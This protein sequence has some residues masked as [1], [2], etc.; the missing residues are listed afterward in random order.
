MSAGRLTHF[1][2]DGHS[3][4][5]ELDDDLMVELD[6][7]VQQNQLTRM[8]FVKS[9]KA[10]ADLMERHPVLVERLHRDK[11]AKIDRAYLASRLREKENRPSMMSRASG[12]LLK[13]FDVTQKSPKLAGKDRRQSD[14]KS[15]MLRAASSG[16]DL[17]FEMD[18]DD[19]RSRQP[20]TP[21][22][23]S[24]V[25][26][27]LAALELPE[28]TE[29]GLEH[30]AASAGSSLAISGPADP[31]SSLHARKSNQKLPW[32]KSAMTNSKLDMKEIMAQASSNRT[33]TISTALKQPE[34]S[35]STSTKLSQKERKKLQQQQQ[36]QQAQPS[37]SQP[38][39]VPIP[40]AKGKPAPWQRASSGPRVSLK[41]VI[42]IEASSHS[43]KK[44][45]MPNSPSMTLRQTVSGR[46][47]AR[48]I[49]SEPAHPSASAHRTVSPTI[50]KAQPSTPSPGRP[51]SSS[52]HARS[53]PSKPTLS[54][55]HSLTTYTAT[56]QSIQ[57]NTP[58]SAEPSLQLS[59]QDILAQQ[60]MQKDVL[61]DAVA[62]R[63]LQ[64]IQEEQAFQEWWDEESR[65]VQEREGEK[66]GKEM[67]KRG[68]RLRRG[69]SRGR[70]R[71]RG[72]G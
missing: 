53:T 19:K 58:S 59:M 18:E 40:Q 22:T 8:S 26:Q 36:L 71:G 43:T 72:G 6:Q 4:L 38:D 9:G 7:V 28:A 27:Q 70:G 13:D 57:H 65:K 42:G 11:S 12:D 41:D 50:S 46:S 54:P 34:T 64:D 66:E 3:L 67:R 15:P 21:K 1:D 49:A 60:Q 2:A 33:S 10:L 25:A 37:S 69:G 29:Y 68:V 48:R 51:T 39:P 55:P 32:S 56:F 23:P 35:R 17:M 62:K 61:K 20:A 24:V 14:A 63:S 30:D 45:A 31:P 16:H 5:G 44:P 47:P 52:S